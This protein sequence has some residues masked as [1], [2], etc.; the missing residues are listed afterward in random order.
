MSIISSPVAWN[1]SIGSFPPQLRNW[2]CMW[3]SLSLL[4]RNML[5]LMKIRICSE[6]FWVQ[7]EA[8]HWGRCGH[9]LTGLG[10]SV[11]V[12]ILSYWRRMLPKWAAQ[13]QNQSHPLQSLSGCCWTRVQPHS[14]PLFIMDSAMLLMPCTYAVYWPIPSWRGD[15]LNLWF[16]CWRSPIQELSGWKSYTQRL[17][18]EQPGL[19]PKGRPHLYVQ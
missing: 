14:R 13:M 4:A 9:F 3:S 10:S 19:V 17:V 5:F 2:S 11:P 15:F 18:A 7:S 1:C 8:M 6:S 12:K 16:L